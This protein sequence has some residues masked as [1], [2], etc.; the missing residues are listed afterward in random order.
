M[1]GN[2]QK[3]KEMKKSSFGAMIALVAMVMG[4]CA[5][6]KNLAD[7]DKESLLAK[8]GD[9]TYVATSASDCPSEKSGI[10]C[11]VEQEGSEEGMLA[12]AKENNTLLVVEQKKASSGAVKNAAWTIMRI[13]AAAVGGAAGQ[14]FAIGTAGGSGGSSGYTT[15][16][17]MV[18]GGNLSKIDCGDYSESECRTN[19]QKMMMGYSLPAKQPSVADA[20]MAEYIK[21]HNK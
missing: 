16:F 19:L 12:Y 13:G 5:T 10:K 20:D 7:I 17:T 14:G 6:S 8:P 4:G 15:S 9:K 18:V 11:L 2:H 21:R 3:G 1:A